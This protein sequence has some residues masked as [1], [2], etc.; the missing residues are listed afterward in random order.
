MGCH[1]FDSTVSFL[2]DCIFHFSRTVIK[3]EFVCFLQRVK[4]VFNHALH[5]HS[6]RQKGSEVGLAM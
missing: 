3:A 4:I 6:L 2:R 5:I 1:L